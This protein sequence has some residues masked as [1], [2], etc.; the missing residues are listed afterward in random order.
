[1]PRAGY[2]PSIP[3][4]ERPQTYRA[5]TGVINV[6]FN[7]NTAW[8]HEAGSMWGI[9]WT[10]SASRAA[11]KCQVTAGSV[12]GSALNLYEGGCSFESLLRYRPLW[13]WYSASI[14]IRPLPSLP[15]PFHHSTNHPT[16]RY[17]DLRYW[18]RRQINHQEHKKRIFCEI[19]SNRS[20]WSNIRCKFN[21]LI[22]H[23]QSNP[24][25][26]TNSF[27]FATWMSSSYWARTGS[28]NKAVC[29]SYLKG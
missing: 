1:M 24:T 27:H 21:R 22:W 15:F 29:A 2:E 9:E 14:W 23:A 18:K 19:V 13:S 3:E 20:P 6:S 4:S 12:R 8:C 25:I 10:Y 17:S 5:A 26:L 16:I 11:L 7:N 28:V